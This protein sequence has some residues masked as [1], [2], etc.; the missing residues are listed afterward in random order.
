MYCM[1]CV[2]GYLVTGW[3]SLGLLCFTPQ[4]YKVYELLER[5]KRKQMLKDAMAVSS[6][7][8]ATTCFVGS[9]RDNASDRAVAL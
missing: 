7:A 6:G 8:I 4:G 5:Y 3:L 9:G 1:Y 2:Y